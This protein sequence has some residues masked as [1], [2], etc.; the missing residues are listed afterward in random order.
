M[1]DGDIKVVYEDI[2][3]ASKVFKSRGEEYSNIVSSG[4][5]TTPAGLIGEL[6]DAIASTL[7]AISALQDS[8]GSSMQAHGDKLIT[9]HTRYSNAEHDLDDLMNLIDD[10]EAIRPRI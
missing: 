8:I 2:L 7:S 9:V 4:I 3:Q 10:P 5:G 6:N 1:S